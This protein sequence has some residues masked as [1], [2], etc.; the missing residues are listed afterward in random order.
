MVDFLELAGQVFE[1]AQLERAG[2]A[3]LQQALRQHR[4]SDD[5]LAD[6]V[7]QP[8]ELVEVDADRPGGGGREPWEP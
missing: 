2:H 8:V 6:E 7:H 3:V 5:Q 4:L 1:V